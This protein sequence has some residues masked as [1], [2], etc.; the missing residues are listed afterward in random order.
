MREVGRGGNEA[1]PVLG[2]IDRVQGRMEGSGR[3]ACWEAL[4]L[5]AEGQAVV[6]LF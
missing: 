3:G 1:Q 5:E 6:C 4:G 2:Q